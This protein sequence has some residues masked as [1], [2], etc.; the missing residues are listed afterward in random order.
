MA[1]SPPTRQAVFLPSVPISMGGVPVEAVFDPVA[2]AIRARVQHRPGAEAVAELGLP[3]GSEPPN[4]WTLRTIR[5]SVPALSG[6]SLSGVWSACQRAHVHWRQ[7]RPRLYSPDPDYEAKRDRILALLRTS[8]ADPEHIVV[9]FLDEMGYMRWPQPA[10]TFTPAAPDPPLQ[11]APAHKE[12]KHRVAAVLDAQSGRV[13]RVDGN[14]VGVAQLR[15]LYRNIKTGYPDATHIYVVQDNWPIHQHEGIIELLQE[16]PHIQQVWL[17]LAAWWLNP[18]EKLWRKL[19]QEVLRLHLLAEHWLDLHKAVRDV[20][21]QFAHGSEELL[22]YV[23]LLGDGP[24]AQA[25][26]GGS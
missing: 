17:P 4:R 15:Q 1:G 6:R 3:D 18:I 5:A 16:Y 8:A 14:R 24:L 22:A 26:R 2:A 23:G 13:L 25:R 20:L 21:R 11:T 12:A 9:L 7:A 10:R 19:R